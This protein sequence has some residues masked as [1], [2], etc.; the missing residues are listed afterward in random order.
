MRTCWSVI[1]CNATLDFAQA[2]KDAASPV[3][4]LFSDCTPRMLA[5]GR[6]QA[7]V[8]AYA[9]YP[10][11]N[12]T[13]SRWEAL[14]LEKY[15]MTRPARYRCSSTLTKG[16]LEIMGS[17]LEVAWAAENGVEKGFRNFNPMRILQANNA[18]CC[19]TATNSVVPELS[20]DAIKELAEAAPYHAAISY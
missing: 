11:W 14:P 9:R 19:F 12:P 7:D 5:F 18:S 17:G 1:S 10:W 3:I 6:L 8:H 16:T 4:Q 15:M 13:R 20:C 2:I